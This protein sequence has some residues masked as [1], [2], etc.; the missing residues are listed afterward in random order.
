MLS[1]SG[2]AHN[3]LQSQAQ[4]K[5]THTQFSTLVELSYQKRLIFDKNLKRS[6][7]EASFKYRLS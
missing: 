2:D 6:I 5:I 3:H 1:N 4:K 7:Q